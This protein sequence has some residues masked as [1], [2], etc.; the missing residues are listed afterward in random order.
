MLLGRIKSPSKSNPCIFQ[1]VPNNLTSVVELA[2]NPHKR[3][4]GQAL[5][6]ANKSIEIVK[7]LLYHNYIVSNYI[8]IG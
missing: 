7:D 8:Y 4:L 1:F 2:T 6:C 5:L 3:T